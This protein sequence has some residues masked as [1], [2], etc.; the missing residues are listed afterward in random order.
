MPGEDLRRLPL[1]G[2]RCTAFDT[3]TT[4]LD[5]WDGHRIV[6]IAWVTYELGSKELPQVTSYMIDPHRPVPTQASDVHGWTDARLDELRQAGHLREAVDVLPEFFAACRGGITLAYNLRFD[7]QMILA[8]IGRPRPA[9]DWHPAGLD[10]MLWARRLLRVDNYRLG[11]VAAH[12]GVDLFGWH[13]AG[14]DTAAAALVGSALLPLLESEGI[15]S[16]GDALDLQR[17]MAKEAER[18]YRRRR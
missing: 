10:P 14:A 8:A 18:S 12:C 7:A 5:A 9:V 4:G 13:D 15:T 16:V 11:T 17:A 2:L 1:A 3:E 6:Q